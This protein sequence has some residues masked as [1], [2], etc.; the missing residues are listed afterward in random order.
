MPNQLLKTVC[1]VGLVAVASSAG[2]R[3]VLA[4]DSGLA[5]VSAFLRAVF[6]EYVQ[7]NVSVE[8]SGRIG[9]DFDLTNFPGEVSYQLW[10]RPPSAHPAIG[11]RNA[12]VQMQYRV[13]RPLILAEGGIW[14]DRR[15]RVRAFTLGDSAVQKRNQE[16]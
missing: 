6:P 4:N 14:L 9:L 16:F 10:D 13:E 2:G 1:C 11:A 5:A 12:S 15:G 3:D 7:R 8:V